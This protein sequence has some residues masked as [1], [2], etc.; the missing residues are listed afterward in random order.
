MSLYNVLFGKNPLSTIVLEALGTSED[1][2]PRFRDAYYDGEANRLVIHTR[3]GGG[4]RDF[5]D[6]EDACR[7]SYPEYF[8]GD[9]PPSGPWNS[10][11]RS[12]PGFLYDRDDDFDC[13]Y[14][15]WFYTVPAA[16][17]PI[18]Q[19][20]KE[21]GGGDDAK[22]ADRWQ[23]MLDGL[24]TGATTTET[25]RALKVGETILS[26]LANSTQGTENAGE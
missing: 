24:R 13:T 20:I 1:A 22:P 25:E 23:S 17:E 14:A 21:L 2:V 9:E 15:D 4:N 5:Y 6:S 12:L 18:F 26:A 16:F 8:N 7:D 11:L 3:T 19:T 10:D